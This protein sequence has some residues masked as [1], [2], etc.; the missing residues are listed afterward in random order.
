[1]GDTGALVIGMMLSILT[2]QF[3]NQDYD[4]SAAAPYKFEASIATAAAFI[5]IPLVDTARIFVLRVYKGQSPFAPD[6]SHIHHAIMR[7]GMTHSQTTLILAGT[8]ASYIALAILL[9][10]VGDFYLL[11]GLVVLSIVLSVVLDRLI[12]RRLS[13]KEELD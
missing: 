8:Q 13:M 4:M 9:R 3:I 6:K 11:P 10:D 7:L 2:I 5:V 12:L 1:M